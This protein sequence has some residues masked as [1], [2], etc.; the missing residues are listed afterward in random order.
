MIKYLI[1]L[2]AMPIDSK[3][4]VFTSCEQIQGYEYN[5]TKCPPGGL[6]SQQFVK[7]ASD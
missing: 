1:Y 2:H 3:M 4:F 6:F 5:L 7:L